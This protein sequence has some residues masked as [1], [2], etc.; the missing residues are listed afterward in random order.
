M[1]TKIKR[2]F[3]SFIVITLVICF[4]IVGYIVYLADNGAISDEL[5]G[6]P[7]KQ[8]ETLL[9]KEDMNKLCLECHIDEKGMPVKDWVIEKY[10][11]QGKYL[12]E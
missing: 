1:A 5:F 11:L 3:T 4:G 6:P 8:T 2:F 9:K 12:H 7:I 10:K